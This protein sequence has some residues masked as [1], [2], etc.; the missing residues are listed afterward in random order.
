MMLQ[1]RYLKLKQSTLKRMEWK[2]EVF[3]LN[4]N[5]VIISSSINELQYKM[6]LLG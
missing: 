2:K 3:I 1:F 4:L 6:S 5:N